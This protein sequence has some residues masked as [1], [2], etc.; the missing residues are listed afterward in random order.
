MQKLIKFLK[1][2]YGN[3]FILAFFLVL[4]QTLQ[5]S[6]STVLDNYSTM[7]Q[8]GSIEEAAKDILKPDDI[9]FLSSKNEYVRN[10]VSQT[11]AS[12]YKFDS[13]DSNGFETALLQ[14][15]NKYCTAGTV[16]DK[17]NTYFIW[18]MDNKQTTM[19][20][21]KAAR[22]L[23]FFFTF[24]A[25]LPYQGSDAFAIDKILRLQPKV[26][27]IRRYCEAN[28]L[29]GTKS[30][31]LIV[32]AKDF[33]PWIG[34]VV[35]GHITW[36][37]SDPTR[38]FSNSNYI[39]KDMPPLVTYDVYWLGQLYSNPSWS[40]ENQD[41]AAYKLSVEQINTRNSVVFVD[42]QTGLGSIALRYLKECPIEQ[43]SLASDLF[44]QL[45]FK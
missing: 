26:N 24:Q 4:W 22:G 21:S 8:F 17:S 13:I 28:K 36:L 44:R 42:R 19:E 12:E 20:M 16:L 25:L 43:S 2:N 34:S 37:A 9:V 11:G 39:V 10:A 3:I 30:V 33:S 6:A 41:N 31:L 23:N 7:R 14:V 18:T 45:C 1:S 32:D 15:L 5:I 27:M 40:F 29:S 38:T 35:T